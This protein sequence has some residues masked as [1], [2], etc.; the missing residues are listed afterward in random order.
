MAKETKAVELLPERLLE[1]DWVMGHTSGRWK[2]CY[3]D[4]GPSEKNVG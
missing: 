4:E 2:R 1:E 3:L